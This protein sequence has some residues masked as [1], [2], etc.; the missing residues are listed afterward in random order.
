MELKKNTENEKE[1]EPHIYELDIPTVPKPTEA[2][3]QQDKLEYHYVD[4][5]GPRTSWIPKVATLEREEAQIKFRKV[6]EE[7]KKN[8]AITAKC[9]K[10]KLSLKCVAFT[11][12]FLLTVF[13]LAL[14]TAALTIGGMLYSR[15]DNIQRELTN[16]SQ[17]AMVGAINT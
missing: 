14:A 2:K 15:L 5:I 8:K 12:L 17:A 13:N 9:Q 1:S 6:L 11:M 3:K 16:A 10:K 7:G 4:S